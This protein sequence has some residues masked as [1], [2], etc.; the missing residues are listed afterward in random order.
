MEKLRMMGE[1]KGEEIQVRATE[2]TFNTVIEENFT[3]EKGRK[4]K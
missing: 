2:N 3:G 4:M 1:N